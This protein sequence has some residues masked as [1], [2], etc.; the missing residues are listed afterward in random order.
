MSHE[1]ARVHGCRSSCVALL[2]R[3]TLRFAEQPHVLRAEALP[4]AREP[5][6]GARAG[7]RDSTVGRLHWVE[8]APQ[9][10]RSPGDAPRRLPRA[11]GANSWRPA[12]DR[13]RRG[14]H[15]PRRDVLRVGTSLLSQHV[16]R[17]C[18]TTGC[19]R[20]YCRL[21]PRALRARTTEAA[22]AGVGSLQSPASG[23]SLVPRNVRHM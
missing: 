16:S 12:R 1:R 21:S 23:A 8:Q 2:P 11:S 9:R 15:R 14:E 5:A 17:V 18:R 6:A 19:R 10:V 20:R 7:E 3:A 22:G 13:A 4:G